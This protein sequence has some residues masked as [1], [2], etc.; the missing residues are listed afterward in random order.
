[1]VQS[2]INGIPESVQNE[3]SKEREHHQQQSSSPAPTQ[4]DA[5]VPQE[6]FQGSN[7]IAFLSF[8]IKLR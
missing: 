8:G 1:M 6:I 4:R 7:S 2:V 3:A 5:S